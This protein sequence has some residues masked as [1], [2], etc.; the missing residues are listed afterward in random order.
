[1]TEN[2]NLLQKSYQELKN[3]IESGKTDDQN[4]DQQRDQTN[5]DP[6]SVTDQISIHGSDQLEFSS[7]QD[8]NL[9]RV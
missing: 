6:L 1:M 9:V 7:D 2:F 8:E 4:F 3:Q 5:F